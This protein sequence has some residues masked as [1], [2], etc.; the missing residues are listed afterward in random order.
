[1]ADQVGLTIDGKLMK[2]P[3]GTSIWDAAQAAGI[4]IP[5]LCHQPRLRPVG[6]CRM[7]VVDIGGRVL[8]PRLRRR[9]DR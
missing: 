6:V 1:M 9:Y 2:V 7:C 4:R 8:R 3:S 5:V